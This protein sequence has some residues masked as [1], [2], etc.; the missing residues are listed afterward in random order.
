MGRLKYK[1]AGALLLCLLGGATV[2][3]YCSRTSY[4]LT[5]LLALLVRARQ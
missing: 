1:Y 2:G 3:A 4:F 5:S